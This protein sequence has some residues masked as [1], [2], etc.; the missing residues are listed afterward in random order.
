MGR[1]RKKLAFW[2]WWG[3][4]TKV[5]YFNISQSKLAIFPNVVTTR[6][7]LKPINMPHLFSCDKIWQHICSKVGLQKF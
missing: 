7:V 1:L 6:V 5:V 4:V 2:W 3:T